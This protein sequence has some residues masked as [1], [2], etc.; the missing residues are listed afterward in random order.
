MQRACGFPTAAR[1]QLNNKMPLDAI[2][3]SL[4]VYLKKESFI[5]HTSESKNHQRVSFDAK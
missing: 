1:R 5:L 3:C 4:C 2:L